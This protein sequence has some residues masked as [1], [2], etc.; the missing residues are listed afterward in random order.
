MVEHLVVDWDYEMVERMV[1]YGDVCLVEMM[2]EELAD[3]S[4]ALTAFE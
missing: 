2:V 4:G 3:D 1:G